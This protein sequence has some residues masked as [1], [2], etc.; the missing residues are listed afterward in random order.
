MMD[1]DIKYL[2]AN[3]IT[4]EAEITFAENRDVK[5]FRR[6]VYVIRCK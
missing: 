3:D 1:I 6:K 5:A 2:S 4:N